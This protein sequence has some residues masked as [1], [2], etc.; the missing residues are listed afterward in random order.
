MGVCNGQKILLSNETHTRGKEA[1]E[2]ARKQTNSLV[3]KAERR[4]IFAR[5]IQLYVTSEY[6]SGV[7]K[8][9]GEN[10]KKGKKTKKKTEA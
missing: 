5:T 3:I 1:Q 2:R 4:C 8:L 10:E 6:S 7:S 9:R